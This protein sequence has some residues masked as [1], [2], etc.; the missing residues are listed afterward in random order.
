M[1]GIE[2]EENDAATH[3]ISIIFSEAVQCL[4]G[5]LV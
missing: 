3:A 2:E 5:L 1:V 4:D